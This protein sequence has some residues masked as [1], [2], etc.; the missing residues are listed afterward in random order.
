M[1]RGR[2]RT[3]RS[4]DGR[5]AAEACRRSIPTQRLVVDRDR[6]PESLRRSKRGGLGILRPV[7]FGGDTEISRTISPRSADQRLRRPRERGPRLETPARSGAL[8]E[9]TKRRGGQEIAG[10]VVDRLDGQW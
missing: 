8:R 5:R 9:P 1:T 3:L 2:L 7:I 6:G 4:P 10:R